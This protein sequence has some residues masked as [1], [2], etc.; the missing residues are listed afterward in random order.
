MSQNKSKAQPS[1]TP[2]EAHGDAGSPVNCS[3]L[4]VDLNA[5]LAREQTALMHADAAVSGADHQRHRDEAQRLRQLVILTPYPTQ[6]R[7]PS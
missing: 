5:L 1:A 7:G 4:P 3:S 6:Q 2:V